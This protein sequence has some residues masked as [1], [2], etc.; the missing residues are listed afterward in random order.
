MVCKWLAVLHMLA[1]AAVC[2]HEQG[3]QAVQM[4]E[5]CGDGVLSTYLAGFARRMLSSHTAECD[6]G[7]RHICAHLHCKLCKANC[8]KKRVL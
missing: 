6:S 2:A 8:M 5:L 1:V 7:M 4:D 3:R